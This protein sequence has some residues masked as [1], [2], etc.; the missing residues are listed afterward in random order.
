[1]KDLSVF[2]SKVGFFFIVSLRETR[3]SVCSSVCFSLTI[4]DLKMMARKLLSPADLAG[5]QVLEIHELSKVIVVSGNKDLVF[6]IF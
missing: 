5:S 4:I 3:K 6:A 1:M 2:S